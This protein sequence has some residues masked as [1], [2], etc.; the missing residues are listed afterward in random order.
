MSKVPKLNKRH[1]KELDELSKISLYTRQK[2]Y[3]DAWP[4]ICNLLNCKEAHI[5]SK[6]EYFAAE[7]YLYGHNVK[8]DEEKAYYYAENLEKAQEFE[9]A[10]NIFNQISKRD[11][12]NFKKSLIKHKASDKIEQYKR[13]G[14]LIN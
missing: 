8:K 3:K 1:K 4:L 12:S 14:F 7:C 10:L 13:R 5:K 2:K 6:A 9:K 11:Q